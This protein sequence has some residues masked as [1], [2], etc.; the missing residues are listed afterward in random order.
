MEGEGKGDEHQKGGSPEYLSQSQWPGNS[1]SEEM[2]DIGHL[3][4]VGPRIIQNTTT[5]NNW[6]PTDC[7]SKDYTE[8]YHRKQ[9]NNHYHKTII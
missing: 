1:T 9:Y 2:R 3:R 4:T 7:G 8:H 6:T 5:E